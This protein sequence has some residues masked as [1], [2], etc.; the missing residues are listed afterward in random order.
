M[1]NYFMD[2]H[3]NMRFWMMDILR[4]QSKMYITPHIFIQIIGNVYLYAFYRGQSKQKNGVN[5]HCRPGRGNSNGV[6]VRSNSQFTLS[7]SL[8]ISWNTLFGSAPAA[9]CGLSPTGMKRMLG[10][11]W[12]PNAPATSRSL[13]VLIL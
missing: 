6:R 5:V 11:L 9:I 1:S 10:M 8:M 4:G 7:T 3:S 13:S 2:S 12:I